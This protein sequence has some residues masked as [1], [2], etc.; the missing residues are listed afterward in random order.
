MS[1][2]QIVN[3]VVGIINILVIASLIL[4]LGSRDL[5]DDHPSVAVALVFM[6]GAFAA[7]NLHLSGVFSG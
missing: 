3:L 4:G 2:W 1:A 6:N 5:W 7:L